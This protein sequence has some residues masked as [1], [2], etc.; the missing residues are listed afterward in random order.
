MPSVA[1]QEKIPKFRFLLDSAFAKPQIFKKLI[2]RASVKHMRH[3]FNLP[4]TT[5]DKEIYQFATQKSRFVLTLDHDFK[6]L[7]RRNATGVFMLRSGLSNEEIDTA[8]SKLISNKNPKDYKGKA[9][10]V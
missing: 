9:T 4:A 1:K 3:D 8:L 5:E 7:V 10:K 2:K 6:K